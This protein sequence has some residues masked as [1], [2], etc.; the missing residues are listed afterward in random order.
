M[1]RYTTTRIGSNIY[2]LTGKDENVIRSIDN[3][4]FCTLSV[5]G[6]YFLN[7]DNLPYS[8]ILKC[9][10]LQDRYDLLNYYRD[11]LIAN[12]G[13]SGVIMDAALLPTNLGV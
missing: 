2:I 13:T 11:V 9:A 4:N 3:P 5:N 6:V 1:Q 10:S 12:S 8:L 7:R